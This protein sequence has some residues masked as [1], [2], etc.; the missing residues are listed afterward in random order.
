MDLCKRHSKGFGIKKIHDDVIKWK[1][2]PRNWPFVRGIHRSPVNSPHKGQCRGAL[3]FTLICARINGWVN[4]PEAGDLRRYRPHYDVIVMINWGLV[5]HIWINQKGHF[6]FRHWHVDYS[7]PILPIQILTVFFNQKLGNPFGK[8]NLNHGDYKSTSKY[9][10][11]HLQKCIQ[12][13]LLQSVGHFKPTS[14]CCYDAI[15]VPVFEH[16]K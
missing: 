2:F 10:N 8:T 4:T 7:V 5:I 1:H 16:N 15:F 11:Y 6:W 12:R 9:S 13:Y 14:M 3:M